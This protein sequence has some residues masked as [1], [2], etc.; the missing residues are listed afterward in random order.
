MAQ[1][2]LR[3]YFSSANN[4]NNLAYETTNAV[5]YL[6]TGPVYAER[7][8]INIIGFVGSNNLLFTE[9]GSHVINGGIATTSLTFD[10]G[11]FVVQSSITPKVSSLPSGSNSGP[12]VNPSTI[13]LT[14]I[15]SGNGDFL[16]AQGYTV[17][18]TDT[19]PVREVLVYLTNK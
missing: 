11:G 8:L 5:N 15:I 16:G 6:N 14:T 19:T 17:V 7:E 4:S 9:K 3:F 10:F 13:A 2:D 1:P 18:V 12:V